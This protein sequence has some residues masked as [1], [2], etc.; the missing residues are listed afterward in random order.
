MKFPQHVLRASK[1]T[2][3]SA[4]L[5][6]LVYR[7]ALELSPRPSIR[8]LCE[9]IGVEH[10]TVATYITRGAFSYPLAAK[11]QEK[12]GRDLAAAEWLTSPLSIKAST[13]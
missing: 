7:M 12:F 10:S 8:A 5:K 13:K 11:M 4:R 3:A 9:I 6:Y 1:K 2:Q